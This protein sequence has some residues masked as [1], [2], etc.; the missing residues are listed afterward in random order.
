MFE[1]IGRISGITAY[2]GRYI[3]AAGRGKRVILWDRETGKSVG[4]ASHDHVVNNCSFSRDG[5]YLVT[6]SSD[7][8]ARLWSVPGLSLK[9]VFAGHGDDVVVSAFHPFDEVIATASRDCFVRVYDFG[10]SLIAKFRGHHGGVGWLG[11]TR[12]G[13]QLIL[14]SDADEVK[15][16]LWAAQQPTD[17]ISAGAVGH[18]GYAPAAPNHA[19]GCGLVVAA[20]TGQVT[21]V[22]AHGK[23]V[24]IDPGTSVLAC[25]SDGVLGVWDI[26]SANPAPIAATTLPDDVW[27]RSCVFAGP[28]RLIFG[29]VGGYRV[30]DYTRDE[31]QVGDMAPANDVHAM[32]VRG[33]D[34]ITVGDS[35]IIRCNGAYLSDA[36]SL[37]NFL[38]SG[39]YGV[40]TGGQDGTIIDATSGHI[41]RLIQVLGKRLDEV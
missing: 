17:G 24:V 33:S 22:G 26:S 16:W 20:G 25:V 2:K 23:R 21:R 18:M 29:T 8:A 40:I 4:S 5:M 15:R 34:I 1:D 14:I 11:W 39:K 27:A 12:D 31:W 10:A 35:G 30:Y 28:S 41:L 38:V 7:C 13:Q 37:C 3:A 36:G 32:C 6:S 9:A 19:N